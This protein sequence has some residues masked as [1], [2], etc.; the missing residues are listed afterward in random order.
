MPTPTYIAHI[1]F[2]R[3]GMSP[4]IETFGDASKLDVFVTEMQGL[5]EVESIST[6]QIAQIMSRQSIW[7]DEEVQVLP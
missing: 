7:V 2:N 5:S 3:T 4:R 1:T 6:Y